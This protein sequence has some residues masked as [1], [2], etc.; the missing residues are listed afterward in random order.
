MRAATGRTSQSRYQ[1]D[2]FDGKEAEGPGAE[3]DTAMQA[4]NEQNCRVVFPLRQ[5]HG[6]LP[7]HRAQLFGTEGG[8]SGTGVITFS[9][10]P[11][12]SAQEFF[13][14]PPQRGRKKA[15][16]Q[17]SGVNVSLPPG[18]QAQPTIQQR[19][20]ALPT[21][22]FLCLLPSWE[23][24]DIRRQLRSLWGAS[25]HLWDLLGHSIW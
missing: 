6:S 3:T 5:E 1:V 14:L 23:S 25:G 13:L 2:V 22:S 8:L 9:G 17:G 10:V 15:G 16:G 20:S 18:V 7:N 24:R 11:G 21:W 19:N 4:F 12:P